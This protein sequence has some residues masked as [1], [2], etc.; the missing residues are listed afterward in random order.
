[1]DVGTEFSVIGSALLQP[2]PPA[3]ADTATRWRGIQQGRERADGREKKARPQQQQDHLLQGPALPTPW[4]DTGRQAGSGMPTADAKVTGNRER[5][6]LSGSRPVGLAGIMP[7]P[8]GMTKTTVRAL[9]GAITLRMT[10]QRVTVMLQGGNTRYNTMQGRTSSGFGYREKQFTSHDN[11][12]DSAL[13]IPS[14]S[15]P[16]ISRARLLETLANIPPCLVGIEACGCPSL[17]NTFG[18]RRL[19]VADGQEIPAVEHG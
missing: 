19:E 10:D 6:L 14:A 13:S 16:P 7:M 3:A 5:I 15:H 11:K 8:P 9:D 4:R 12:G 1:M 2:S 17:G 18:P